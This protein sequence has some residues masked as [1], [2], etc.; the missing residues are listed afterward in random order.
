MNDIV[1]KVSVM[2]ATGGPVGAGPLGA[3]VYSLLAFPVLVMFNG[4]YYFSAHMAWAV[5]LAVAAVSVISILVVRS[6]E[7]ESVIVVDK[8]LGLICALLFVPWSLKIMAVGFAL[9]HMMRFVLPIICKVFFSFDVKQKLGYAHVVVPSVL[10]GV[11][12]NF[13]LRFALW[14]AR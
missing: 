2:I 14:L 4:L 11:M 8:V 12:V 6:T 7:Y 13:V 1:K 10:T 9:F 5:L 3:L